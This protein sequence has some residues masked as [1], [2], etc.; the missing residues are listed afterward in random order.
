MIFIV[1]S[2]ALVLAVFSIRNSGIPTE[3]PLLLRTLTPPIYST[4]PF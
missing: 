2:R 1:F 3:V 4:N